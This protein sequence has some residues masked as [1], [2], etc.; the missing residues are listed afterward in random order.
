MTGS[1]QNGESIYRVIQDQFYTNGEVFHV[2]V[3]P[4]GLSRILKENIANITHST[5][6]NDQKSLFQVGDN[7]AIEEIQL[8]D[9]DF[10]AMFSFPLLKG[11]PKKVL[12]NPHSM[13]ISEKMASKYF[14]KKDPVG[15]N[16]MLEGKYPFTITGII[17]DSPK[18][19]EISYNFLIPFDFYKELGENVES[20]GQQLDHNLCSIVTRDFSRYGEQNN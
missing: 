13:V 14:G 6:Y 10:F 15:E 7:K 11:D 8:I 16:V 12:E 20:L 18:N 19:T 3:T 2:Q 5:R 4:P 17:K 1:I 9:S